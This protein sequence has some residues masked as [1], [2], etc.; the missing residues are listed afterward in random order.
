MQ[1]L[2]DK[3]KE[4]VEQNMVPTDEMQVFYYFSVFISKEQ[5][6]KYSSKPK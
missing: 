1:I 4:Q 6:Q 5:M 3:L 2:R